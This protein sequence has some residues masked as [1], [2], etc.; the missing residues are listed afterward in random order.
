[1]KNSIKLISL[2]ALI[3]ACSPDENVS[4]VLI[5]KN[6]MDGIHAWTEKHP[7]NF[8]R[9]DIAY[10]GLYVCKVNNES[11]YSTTF[12]VKLGDINS[13]TLK[14]LKVSGWIQVPDMNAQATLVV[15]LLDQNKQSFDYIAKY[16]MKE[17][18]DTNK[19]VKITNEINLST[20]NRNNPENF[21]KVYFTNNA[22]Q[23]LLVDDMIVEFED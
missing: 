19:W 1:M 6:N 22:Q 20:G 17:L 11:P 15:D 3:T 8:I 9:T 18:K 4:S 2:L 21:V 5:F 12:Y 13:K 23:P 14:K 16:C 7:A 10:S